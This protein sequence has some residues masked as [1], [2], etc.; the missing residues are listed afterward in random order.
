MNIETKTF[1]DGNIVIPIGKVD[2]YTL[3]VKADFTKGTSGCYEYIYICSD[4][5]VV[6][7]IRI[8]AFCN[9]IHDG[10]ENPRT[11]IGLDNISLDPVTN[12]VA[13]R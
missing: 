5:T 7:R 9:I 1:I 3:Y 10:S 13:R 12:M 4:T 2:I 8:D 11:E 6:Q